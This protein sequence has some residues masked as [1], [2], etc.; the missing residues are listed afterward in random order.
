MSLDRSIEPEI[1]PVDAV[2]LGEAKRISFENERPLFY[3]NGGDQ[4]VVQLELI[5][6][7]GRVHEQKRLT[8]QLA[9]RLLT[10]GTHSRKA[11]EIAEMIDFHGAHLEV[12]AS[13]DYATLN[14]VS[15]K[16]HLPT[17][18]PLVR[19][20]ITE[21]AFSEEELVIQKQRSI[22]QL[23]VNEE[24][25]DY[26]AQRL[27]HKKVF[28]ADHPYGYSSSTGNYEAVEAQDLS[29]F[30]RT[31]GGGSFN[32]ALA[33]GNI[34][35]ATIALLNKTLGSPNLSSSVSEQSPV[36]LDTKPGV[37]H[38]PRENAQQSS[39]RIGKPIIGI[40][41]EDHAELQVLNTTFGGYFGSR[42]MSNIREDKG[43]T[44]GIYSSLGAFKQTGYWMIAT[45]VGKAV[46][47]EAI[48]EIYKELETLRS[49]P[50]PADELQLVKNYIMGSYLSQ[51]DG[52]FAQAKVHKRL[53][54]Y[55]QTT[56]DFQKR[57]EK[58]KQVTPERLLELANRYF[59]MD[60][61]VEAVVG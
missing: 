33:A 13:Y 38:E 31:A 27:F 19:E 24:K 26:L 61:I 44:Y 28:G 32:Y 25:T 20:I 29:E 60:G 10:E 15:L 57:I 6:S 58:V 56:S 14:L 42:L 22:Q 12:G 7:G 53:I 41:H 9:A 48:A 16:K 30:Y 36:A 43:F 37:Y 17:L 55:N 45:E 47:K 46:A 18:L 52:P 49:T 3:M 5:Y 39:I 59:T 1:K 11:A 54:N 2:D 35:D 50:I 8:A 51:V 21:P 40:T 4:D 34:D 23:L